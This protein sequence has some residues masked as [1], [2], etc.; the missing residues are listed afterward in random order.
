[1]TRQINLVPIAHSKSILRTLCPAP[2]LR[3]MR[4]PWP[5]CWMAMQ[6]GSGPGAWHELRLGGPSSISRY[7]VRVMPL[8]SAAIEESA[9]LALFL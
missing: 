5:S 6:A 8:I 7:Q 3:T 2:V 4:L 9:A 1:M